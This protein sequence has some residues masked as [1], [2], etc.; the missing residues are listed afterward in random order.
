MN[1]KI[2]IIGG[3]IIGLSLGWQL[4]KRGRDVE[5]FERDDGARSAA[6]ASAGML[7]PQAELGFEEIELFNLCRISL[8][9]FHQFVEQLYKDSGINLEVDKCGT[10]MV[11]FDRD[12]KERLKRLFDFRE[13]V[14]VPAK[15][16]SGTEAREIE[17][18]LSPN[19]SSA[20][21]IEEDAQ[22]DNRKLLEALKT[23]Y[24]NCGGK[25]YE[26]HEIDN[27]KIKN[28][29]IEGVHVHG[30]DI[31]FDTV[32]VCAGSWSK[33]I[34]GIPENLL[35]PVR[36]VKGQI[37]S[38]K[39]EDSCRLSHALR[40]DNVYL[41]PKNDGRLVIGAT[42][43][44]AGFDTKPTAGAVKDLLEDAWQAVPAIHDLKIESVDVG[45]RPGSRDSAPIIGDTEIEGLY[46]ATGHYRSGVLLAPVT[47]YELSEWIISSNP[48]EVLKPFQLS[49][50]YKETV[51]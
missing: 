2:S 18:L 29:K 49:R 9:L 21:W 37:I 41:V 33:M 17:P 3:G 43:E 11:G 4:A 38:L 28:G 50:F 12:D 24:I 47:A 46:F 15:W 27:V 42:V 20:I 22:I 19:C 48:S 1:D 26:N 6:W 35:P 8:K 23:A 14:G 44:E 32:I 36:P 34:E 39:S 5:I 10:L 7:A 40:N 13:K 51:K 31:N 45:L 25:F 16:L 30:I